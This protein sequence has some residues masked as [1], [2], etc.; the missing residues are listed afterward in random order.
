[1]AEA[2]RPILAANWKMHLLRADA[3]AFCQAL[4]EGLCETGVDIV[5]FPSAPLLPWVAQGLEGLPAACG[6]Q[7]VHPEPRG[8]HTGDVSAAQ[9]RD[10]GCSW[11]LCGHSERRQDHGETDELVGRKAR[12]ANDHG[13]AAL[14]CL[15]ETREERAAGRTFEVLDRQLSAAL[16]PGL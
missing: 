15:G 9:L 1:M 7:D 3:E 11:A 10:A 16:A 4:R 2:R 8:A 12:A 5:I 13:L 14:V 6:G